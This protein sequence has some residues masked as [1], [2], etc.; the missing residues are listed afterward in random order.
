MGNLTAEMGAA[1]MVEVGGG[2]VG[3]GVSVVSIGYCAP[4]ASTSAVGSTR[5]CVLA[6]SSY[7]VDSG[8]FCAPPAAV[9]DCRATRSSDDAEEERAPAAAGSSCASSSE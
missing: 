2:S 9:E 7:N 6:A 4:V 8:G 1:E 5:R 3:E